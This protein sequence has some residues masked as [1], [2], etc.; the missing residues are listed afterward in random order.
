[1]GLVDLLRA[2]ADRSA[3]EDSSRAS[4]KLLPNGRVQLPARWRAT[5]SS[6]IVPHPRPHGLHASDGEAG[7]RFHFGDHGKDLFHFFSLNG[8][9]YVLTPENP[10]YKILPLWQLR[11][12]S[13]FAVFELQVP[14]DH[15]PIIGQCP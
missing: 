13:L 15:V 11:I 9:Q 3:P 14:H 2:I 7:E 1:M 8:V 12:Y 5:K 4:S 10:K 6:E